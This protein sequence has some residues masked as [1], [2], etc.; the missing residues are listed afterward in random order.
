MAIISAL[1]KGQTTDWTRAKNAA[2]R[3][4][5][6]NYT[7]KDYYEDRSINLAVSVVEGAYVSPPI[8]GT[9]LAFEDQRYISPPAGCA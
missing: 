3:I 6:E 9:R 8:F 4:R 1:M 7:L 5:D 2:A